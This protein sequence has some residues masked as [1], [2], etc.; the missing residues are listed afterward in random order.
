MSKDTFEKLKTASDSETV[1]SPDEESSSTDIESADVP[2]LFTA[3]GEKTDSHLGHVTV[4]D[5]PVVVSREENLIRSYIDTDRRDRVRIGDYVRIPYPP[6]SGETDEP[7]KQ[8]FA[9]VSRLEYDAKTDIKDMR[10]G[11]YEDIVGE[12]E[13]TYVADFVPISIVDYNEDAEEMEQNTVD[14]PP[15][16]G[17]QTHI[18]TDEEFLRT[19]LRIPHEGAFLGHMAVSGDRIPSEENPLAYNLFNPNVTDGTES[20]GESALFRHIQVAGSTG[21]GKTHFSKN[22]LRQLV[23]KKR[24][25]IDIPLEEREEAGSDVRTRGLNVV[26]IDP[27]DEYVEMRDDPSE[28]SLPSDV[29]EEYRQQGIEVGGL[30]NA[31]GI[32]FKVFAPLVEGA[33]PEVGEYTGFSIPFS[34]V[35][36]H[37]TI[38]LASDPPE[39]TSAAILDTVDRYFTQVPRAQQSYAHFSNW[40]D[41]LYEEGGGGDAIVENEAVQIAVTDR[42]VDRTEYRRIFDHGTQSLTDLTSEMF[43]GDQVTV[44][45]TAHLRGTVDKL[46]VSC[47]LS[48]I[49]QNKIG[50][51]V[52][53]PQIKGT[54]MLL[55]LDEAHEYISSTDDTR[56]R[57]LVS[58]YR[59]AAKRGRKDLLGLYNIT[60][61]PADIDDEVSKQ[62]NT[63]IY[64][65]LERDV[66]ESHGVFVPKDFTDQVTQFGKGQAVVK[67][68]DVRAVEIVGL[69]HCLTRHG[70][71]N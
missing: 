7:L 70:N 18:V 57:Y 34:M 26:I 52:R 56:E 27:E 31:P 22:V 62:T 28:N 37:P 30:D 40:V 65:G 12:H 3:R 39:R 17:A 47:I 71:P 51:S 53:Y 11:A 9:V 43:R 64:L 29:A 14:K 1:D 69:P 25:T 13:R 4:E 8:L 59:R 2:T 55:A 32:D 5:E 63:R 48:H 67:Q 35:R 23:A 49:V 58:Q 66:A 60:Q 21:K 19:G 68:P 41:T 42:L 24:Y 6:V 33:T 45:P 36:S 46:V 20:E 50:S 54:P 38:M 15:T 61:N 44:F 16:P 10:D